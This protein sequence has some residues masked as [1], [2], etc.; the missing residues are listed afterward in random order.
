[1]LRKQAILVML[2]ATLTLAGC[3]TAQERAQEH[4]ASA[5]EFAAKGDLPHAVVEFRNVFQ[6]DSKNRDARMAYARMLKGHGDLPAAYGQYNQITEWYPNDIEAVRDAA[7]TAAELSNWPEAKR[8]VTAGLALAPTDPDL[9]AVQAA[10]DY[11]AGV[12]GQDNKSWQ[13]AAKAAT[14]MLATR[15]DDILLRRVVFD[16]LMRGED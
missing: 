7:R 5:K 12:S 3:K 16:S 1:M 10:V 6:L 14:D 9:L 13:A 15:P 2:A 8:Q 4:F 11:S